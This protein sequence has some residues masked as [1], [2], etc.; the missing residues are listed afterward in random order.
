MNEE[1]KS[2]ENSCEAEC[3]KQPATDTKAKRERKKAEGER[4]RMPKNLLAVIISVVLVLC[5]LFT[6][7]IVGLPKFVGAVKEAV[8]DALIGLS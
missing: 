1:N 6:V 5:T 2:F 4:K 3:A 7:L 8:T